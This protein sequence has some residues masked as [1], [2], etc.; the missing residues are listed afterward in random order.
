MGLRGRQG[1][2]LIVASV[3][4]L[5]VVG[6][7][8]WLALSYGTDPFA[9]LFSAKDAKPQRPQPET[10]DTLRHQGG[11]ARRRH[12]R[13]SKVKVR[14]RSPPRGGLL[15]DLDTGRVLWR[16]H[17]KRT[18]PI[19]SLT[20]IATA[21]VTV[22]RTA[23]GERLKIPRSALEVPGSGIGKLRRGKRVRVD[24]LLYGLML[25]SANDAAVALAD[26]VAGSKGR[27]VRLMNRR[28]RGLGLACTRFVSPHGLEPGNRSC[29]VDLAVLT[30]VAMSKRRIVRVVRR[31]RAKLRFPVKTGRLELNSTNPL[32]RTGYRGAVGLKTGYTDRAGRCFVGVAKRGSRRLGVVLLHSPDPN[33]QARRLLDAGFRRKSRGY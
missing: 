8:V 7:A 2:I 17:A 13:A 15:F 23:P 10:L 16:L 31:D 20:K 19:A 4:V 27:F 21:I 14:L 6:A 25:A 30:Q 12:P 9:R 32:L 18:L 24:A 33:R 26:H 11:A 3:A 5:L 29:A 1:P 28:A 22:E